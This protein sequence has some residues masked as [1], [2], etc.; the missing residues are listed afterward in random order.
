MEVNTLE[1]VDYE[2]GGRHEIKKTPHLWQ[3]ILIQDGEGNW[4]NHNE[5]SDFQAQD[6][7]LVCPM[8]TMIFVTAPNA[9]C[10]YTGL[11][12]SA[13][14]ILTA[15]A[16]SFALE[17]LDDYLNSHFTLKHMTL[18]DNNYHTAL[19]FLRVIHS[20]HKDTLSHSVLIRQ[21]TLNAL[22]LVLARTYFLLKPDKRQV[23]KEPSSRSAMIEKTKHYI[24]QNYSENL[25]LSAIAD[26]IYTNPSYLSRIFKETTGINLSLYIN[27]VRISQVKQRLLDTDEL[28]VD[29]ASA[30][31]FNYIP[32]F[33]RVFKE[34]EGM[35]P[36]KYR[37]LH[38]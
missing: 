24:N 1:I 33:N 32:H 35:T 10:K 37:S 15:A 20:I 6:C 25:P 16:N 34:L 22:L 11:S 21:Y 38:K 30:C 26:Y 7:F 8:E 18:V 28:M 27:Q 2:F 31:G 4:Q 29:I 13:G 17:I 3:L 23:S 36:G 14:N 5:I 9:T 12:F 19:D